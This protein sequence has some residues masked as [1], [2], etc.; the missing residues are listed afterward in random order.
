M[1]C[2]DCGNKVKCVDTMH[3]ES[4]MCT[5]RRYECKNCRKKIYTM[6][7]LSNKNDVNYILSLKWQNTGRLK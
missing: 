5:A 7:K 2:P 4:T 6:E 1:T 3:D